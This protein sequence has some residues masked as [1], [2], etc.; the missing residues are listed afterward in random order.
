LAKQ[1]NIVDGM[2]R[3]IEKMREKMLREV[4]QIIVHIRNNHVVHGEYPNTKEMTIVTILEKIINKVTK[5]YQNFKSYGQ[6]EQVKTWS[7]K[8]CCNMY[9]GGICI[10]HRKI[11]I[12]LGFLENL[13]L[14]SLATFLFINYSGLSLS[15]IQ[16]FHISWY[17]VTYNVTKLTGL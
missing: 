10:T 5:K 3:V 14:S 1:P 16:V 9:I 15:L 11:T 4:A 7:R 12:F 2:P 8:S 17:Q 6:M 13:S